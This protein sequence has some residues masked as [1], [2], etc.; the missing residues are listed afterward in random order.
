MI[1]VSVQHPAGMDHR[2]R[3]RKVGQSE[4]KHPVM[5]WSYKS[6]KKLFTIDD[7]AVAAVSALGY[8]FGETIA[9]LSGWPELLC[10]AAS[11]AVGLVLEEI[12]SRI[13]FCEAVQR[14]PVKRAFIYAAAFS[15]FLAGHAVSRR[16]MGVSLSDYLLEEYVWVIVLPVLGFAVNLLIR[17]LRIRKIRGLYGDGSKGYVFDVKKEDIEDT[18]MQNRPVSGGYDAGLAVKTRTGIYVGE[19]LEKTI[20]YLGIPYAKPPVGALRWKAPEPLPSSDAVFEAGHFGASAIQV[21]HEGV[22]IKHH[23]QSEDCLYVN[24]CVGAKGTEGKKPVLV[25]FH[26]GD[27]TSGGSVDPLLY[28]SNYINA[29]PDTVFVSFNYRLGIFGFIDFSQVP[30]GDD[31][32]DAPNLGL[33]DQV[34]ALKWIREN[35]AAFGGDPERITV[36]GFESGAS[37]ILLLAA[38]GKAKDLFRKAFVFFGSPESAYVTPDASRALAKKLLQETKTGSMQELLQLK[39][40]SLKA[41]GQ[42]LWQSMCGPVC[43]GAWIPSDM[44][45]AYREGAAS[46]I[47]FI[48]GI[49]RGE[50]AVY[51]S[52]I[53]EE[54][55]EDLVSAEAAYLE[56]LEDRTGGSDTLEEK[57]KRLERW[58]L[59]SMYRSAKMLAKGGSPVHLLYWDEKP[60]IGKLGSGTV[61]AAATLL[62]NGDALLLYGNVMNKDLSEILQSLLQ[63][64]VSGEAM[65]LY[66]NEI[67]GV[68]ALEWNPFPEALI[69]SEETLRCGRIE[70]LL[71]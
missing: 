41:A 2:N 43:D 60:L 55:Y 56:D 42:T 9:W 33:L 34:A 4:E 20:C 39:T 69:V 28:G 21:A 47:E 54:K 50:M 62:G 29:H 3:G 65:E 26:H 25:L 52:F 7:F 63:K 12:M 51:R 14:E 67:R 64:Y 36:M 30:G 31:Y 66:A 23:R 35:I 5:V 53:G 16:W 18:N 17:W 38:G 48:I 40:E 19:K 59:R 49:P 71:A 1:I 6:M 13:A 11:F 45:R 37:S 70:D 22:I 27:F 15:L 46:G 57:E 8:G 32:T 44:Y 61:D 24:I 68:D 10:L 58:Y